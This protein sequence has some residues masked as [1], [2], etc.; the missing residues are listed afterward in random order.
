MHIMFGDKIFGAAPREVVNLAKRCPTIN[1]SH[2]S[3]IARSMSY[4]IQTI[5]SARARLK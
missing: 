3:C 5:W 4:R 2:E 1:L